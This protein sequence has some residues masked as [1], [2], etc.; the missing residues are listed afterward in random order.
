MLRVV[1]GTV[2]HTV[3]QWRRQ[4]AGGE[5]D[6]RGNHD[7]SGGDGSD[8]GD[9]LKQ[10]DVLMMD[11]VVLV[12]G[13]SRAIPVQRTVRRALLAEK[14]L[15]PVPVP[16]PAS[17]L[18]VPVQALSVP[19]QPQTI[20]APV[21]IPSA[22][23]LPLGGMGGQGMLE[24]CSSVD[25]ELAV[26]QGLAIRGAVLSGREQTKASRLKVHSSLCVCVYLCMGDGVYESVYVPCLTITHTR[27]YD[28]HLHPCSPPSCFFDHFCRCL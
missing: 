19:V 7:V 15:P 4:A 9:T 27:A 5:V 28:P 24:F 17:A 13:S 16:V 18:S 3:Q 23:E 11:E 2:R 22:N 6:S 14:A 12:G 25:C 26:V 8:R 21:P 1:E 20:S 10:D